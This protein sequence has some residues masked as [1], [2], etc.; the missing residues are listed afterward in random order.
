MKK[1]SA[2]IVLAILLGGVFVAHAAESIYV[3]LV[4]KQADNTYDLYWMKLDENGKLVRG[5]RLVRDSAGG[6]LQERSSPR[7]TRWCSVNMPPRVLR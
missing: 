4:R 2:F 6:L 5:P 1:T 7:E 3:P